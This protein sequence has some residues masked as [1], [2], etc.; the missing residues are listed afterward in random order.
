MSFGV[1]ERSRARYE[2]GLQAALDIAFHRLRG[3]L[4]NTLAG[5]GKTPLSFW[6][7]E[8]ETLARTLTPLLK[9]GLRLG[10]AAEQTHFLEQ[11]IAVNMQPHIQRAAAQLAQA[12]ARQVID[13]LAGRVDELTALWR[14]SRKPIEA[15]DDALQTSVL[16]RSYAE[17]IAATET[18]RAIT[19]GQLLVWR[20]TR[21]P[22]KYAPAVTPPDG[23]A[24]VVGKRWRVQ[25]GQQVCPICEPLD[26][27][28]V[29]LDKK[30]ERAG[31]SV[32]APPAHPRCRCSL[33]PVWSNDVFRKPASQAEDDLVTQLQNFPHQYQEWLAQATALQN[34]LALL[35]QQRDRIVARISSGEST[36][37]LL[38]ELE[39]LNML[40]STQERE[41][42]TIN[43]RL[44]GAVDE[45][46]D[47]AERVF[48]YEIT[49]DDQFF[50]SDQQRVHLL[51]NLVTSNVRIVDYLDT[52]GLNRPG[53]EVF[54]E[55]FAEQ[56]NVTVELG[57]NA[58]TDDSGNPIGRYHGL[59]PTGSDIIY[60]GSAVSVA[61][62]THEFFHQMN[63]YFNM[64]LTSGNAPNIM[65]LPDYLANVAVNSLRPSEGLPFQREGI[66]EGGASDDPD[67]AE[68]FPD[69]AM[70]AVLDNLGFRVDEV[71]GS[72]V[73]RFV[74]GS[75]N[76]EDVRCGIR[77]YFSQIL[78]GQT[79][80]LTYD[81][82][83]CS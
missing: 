59:T 38:N 4:V 62:I 33:Q 13:T 36:S 65:S 25:R 34:Q 21:P 58:T 82:T 20:A 72:P 16:S 75:R 54:R 68:R 3:R 76:A 30:F 10:V 60:L 14:E 67:F 61:T 45:Y 51:T 23:P 43:E 70:A 63:R 2:A 44:A 79:S 26:G 18:T 6:E 8:E 73:V 28:V 57:A 52:L 41:L 80:E 1:A 17:M 50:D 71:N 64:A 53:L 37:F 78:N 35:N 77:Q 31:L 15:F 42:A 46:A 7:H 22:A 19:S 47:L 29:A 39:N 32:D 83:L 55:I 12:V 48:G 49:F 56:G 11:G 69:L 5:Q 74:P 81:V 27:M 40:I 9:D 24:F 66:I